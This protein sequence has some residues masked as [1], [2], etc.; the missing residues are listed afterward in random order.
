MTALKCAASAF[1]RFAQYFI[2]RV[3]YNVYRLYYDS[4]TNVLQS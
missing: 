1:V 3:F 4:I 2:A